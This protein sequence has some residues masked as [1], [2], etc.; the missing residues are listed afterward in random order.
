MAGAALLGAPN[1]VWIG[2]PLGLFVPWD[3][4]ATGSLTHV[5]PHPVDDLLGSGSGSGSGRPLTLTRLADLDGRVW[6][7]ALGAASLMLL[8]GALT[9]VRLPVGGAGLGAAAFAGRCAAGPAAAP[10]PA[11]VL[12]G[13]L[14]GVSADAS[15]SVLGLDAFGAGIELHQRWGVAVL[16]GAA[17]GAGAG[18]A[19]GFCSRG[20]GGRSAGGGSAVRRGEGR[21]GR[22]WWLG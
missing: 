5:L 17:W 12:L 14:A 8:A 11:L 10:A 15:L 4:R 21:C 6:L 3:G 1:G 2:V 19:G 16:L 18:A 20:G 9:G 7:L 22:G 13:W